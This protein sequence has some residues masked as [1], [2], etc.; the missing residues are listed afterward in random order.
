MAAKVDFEVVAD[1]ERPSAPRQQLPTG[2]GLLMLALKALSQRTIVALANL[3][4]LATVGS[5]FWLFLSIDRPDTHQLVQM[6]MYVVFILGINF[7][8]RR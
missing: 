4:T 8:V 7:I 3:F 6:A 5:A 2:A 1:N